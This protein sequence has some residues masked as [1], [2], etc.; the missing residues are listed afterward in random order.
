MAALV[1]INTDG[2]A[3][4]ADTISFALGGTAR[5]ERKMAEAKAYVAEL[6]AKTNNKIALIKAQGEDALANYVTA[7]ELRKMRNTIAV[8]EKAQS[9]FTEG[10]TV[11]DEPVNE[12]WKNRFFNIVEEMSDE[13]LREIW[14]CA[15]AGEI[16]KPKSYSLRT[17]EVLRNLAIEE[18]AII[19]KIAPY[20]IREEY[21]YRECPLTI[22]ENY[23]LQDCGILLD[24]GHSI[25]I[26]VDVKPHTQHAITLDSKNTLI[27]HNDS[28]QMIT[29]NLNI[30]TLSVAGQEII[31]LVEEDKE[32]LNQFVN[33]LV[34]DLFSCGFSKVFKH[35]IIKIDGDAIEFED[36]GEEYKKADMDPKGE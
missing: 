9:H 18:A 23:T 10:E 21:I 24:D 17:L 2:L 30:Y 29:Y 31:K 33:K 34:Q 6:E 32:I 25:Q 36:D 4:L 15:L 8:I 35:R 14:G 7:K 3:K 28:D 19:V 5:G 13:E 1:E 26:G 20:V 11:S 27:V 22:E 16:K 12:G